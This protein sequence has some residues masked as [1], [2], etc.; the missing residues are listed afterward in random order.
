[1]MT[2]DSYMTKD[3]VPLGRGKILLLQRNLVP[4]PRP[5]REVLVSG[6]VIVKQREKMVD[7]LDAVQRITARGE[8]LPIGPLRIAK[9][10][11]K[12]WVNVQ[13]KPATS[14]VASPIFHLVCDG[15]LT[16]VMIGRV[17]SHYRLAT[18]Q[19]HQQRI[20]ESEL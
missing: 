19:D 14:R 16:Q 7:V 4:P 8:K 20:Q 1:M 10:I 6:F 2:P 13:G 5:K 18:E 9:E 3:G 11:A 12:P 15:V 17:K